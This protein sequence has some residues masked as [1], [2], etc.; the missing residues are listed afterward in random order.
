M[1]DG[2]IAH[3]EAEHSTLS[4]PVKVL[5]NMKRAVK[6]KKEVFYVVEE[7]KAAKLQNIV[8]DPVNR[9]GSQHRDE[10]GSYSY[11]TDSQGE[12][13]SDL[14]W[15]EDAEYRILEVTDNGVA[16]Y[17]DGQT[18]QGPANAAETSPRSG[19]EEPFTDLREIDH[20]VLACIREEK[21]DTN[22][23]TSATG[24]TNH[25]VTYSFRKLEERGLIHVG[26]P[27]TV[28]RFTGGQKRV[29]EVNTAGLTEAGRQYLEDAG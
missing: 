4:R 10:Y 11:Y 1:P 7:G 13:V 3:L 19:D 26:E 17:E 18:S 5:R 9:N 27:E 16:L 21:D 2:D 23:I 29:F 28:E 24:Y 15:L 8:S 25:R 6:Q 22:L 20:A 12:P 14:A